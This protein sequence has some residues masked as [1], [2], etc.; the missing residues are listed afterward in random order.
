MAHG[1]PS[2]YAGFVFLQF[3]LYRVLQVELPTSFL[4]NQNL[5]FARKNAQERTV[6]VQWSG[7]S[8]EQAGEPVHILPSSQPILDP[9]LL[10]IMSNLG[11]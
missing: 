3:R 6:V 4:S 9:V 2:S 5:N 10:D 1:R 8:V 11:T 7:I